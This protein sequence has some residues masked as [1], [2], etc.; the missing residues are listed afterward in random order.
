[1][2]TRDSAS[3]SGN[4]SRRFRVSETKPASFLKEDT[5]DGFFDVTFW[6]TITI[7]EAD[8]E[9]VERPNT[10]H[11]DIIIATPV[12]GT[13]YIVPIAKT[14]HDTDTPVHD[15]IKVE[16][17]SAIIYP[18]HQS[19]TEQ[20]V[21]EDCLIPITISCYHPDDENHRD[22][23]LEG[24]CID[25]HFYVTTTDGREIDLGS[26]SIDYYRFILSK[27][28]NV[29]KPTEGNNNGNGNGN[30]GGGNG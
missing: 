30:N 26:E 14:L 11:G 25:L 17:A 22:D 18:N 24:N 4:V 3:R 13:L 16:P 27:N 2:F 7:E 28:W 10:L 5:K 19:L 1:M 9:P 21:I 20:G 12:L 15:A 23:A 29:P 8:E 6:H